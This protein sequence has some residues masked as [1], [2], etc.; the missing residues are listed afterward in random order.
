MLLS[1][2]WICFAQLCI[3]IVVYTTF[4]CYLASISHVSL[5]KYE[6]GLLPNKNKVD[7]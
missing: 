5:S 2:N 1:F 3:F 4:L 7:K 6:Q